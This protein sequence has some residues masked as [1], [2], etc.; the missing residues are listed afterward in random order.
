ML[1]IVISNNHTEEDLTNTLRSIS[2]A[3]PDKNSVRIKIL[4]FIDVTESNTNFL[5][6]YDVTE[7]DV[8]NSGTW[9]KQ[10][11]II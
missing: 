7:T 11:K 3:A 1:T 10:F 6:E 5:K 4:N 8:K 2:M 9:N